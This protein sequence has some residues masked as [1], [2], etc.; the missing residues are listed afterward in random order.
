MRNPS[1]TH[2]TLEGDLEFT[3]NCGGL[4]RCE[5]VPHGCALAVDGACTGK[6]NEYSAVVMALGKSGVQLVTFTVELFDIDTSRI[7]YAS[8]EQEGARQMFFFGSEAPERASRY[9]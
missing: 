6:V 1:T 3:I 9:R 4:Q 8:G 5:F 2:D 7:R